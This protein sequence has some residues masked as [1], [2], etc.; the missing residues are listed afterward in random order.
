[1]NLFL[2]NYVPLENSVPLWEM[3]TDHFLHH[4]LDIGGVK[5]WMALKNKPSELEDTLDDG[6]QKHEAR[7]IEKDRPQNMELREPA[8]TYPAV[9]GNVVSSSTL[10]QLHMQ[11]QANQLDEYR[12]YVEQFGSQTGA[13]VSK[14]ED[15]DVHS[16]P[17]YKIFSAHFQKMATPLSSAS[18]VSWQGPALAVN[19]RDEMLYA[20]FVAAGSGVAVLKASPAEKARRASY[21]QWLG[22]G[23]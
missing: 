6:K 18:G 11:P 15:M 20:T 7:H 16:H 13:S 3:V 23:Q 5:R 4:F 9:K 19:A 2:G 21:S 17:D 1:M 10:A 22:V 12:R 14:N 8:R